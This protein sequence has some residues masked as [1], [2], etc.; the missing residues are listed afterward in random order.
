MSDVSRK[1]PDG[2]LL[3][4]GS[5][6][7]T[8]PADKQGLLAAVDDATKRCR[9]VLPPAVIQMGTTTI[10]LPDNC[11]FDGSGKRSTQ[12]AFDEG[13]GDAINGGSDLAIRDLSVIGP[14][15]A[16]N[17]DT[18]INCGTFTRATNVECIGF[19]RNFH[20]DGAF[21]SVIGPGSIASNQNGDTSGVGIAG[22]ITLDVSSGSHNNTR[23][24]GC[25]LA[26]SATAPAINISANEITVANCGFESNDAENTIEIGFG[27]GIRLGMLRFQKPQ[28]T[29]Q[30]IRTSSNTSGVGAGFDVGTDAGAPSDFITLNGGDW[31]F[32]DP[33]RTDGGFTN[34]ANGGT[35]EN[36]ER[37][38]K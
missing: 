4:N 38:S 13:V 3:F 35:K 9:I 7:R 32:S 31:V 2:I 29:D 21:N 19:V 37:F 1:L 34:I 20:L 26:N 16:T 27:S 11:K 28:T 25:Y 22:G 10:S 33:I 14:N 23:I 15:N 8:F 5:G 24:L 6:V 12:L 18:G 36:A 17:T 30:V